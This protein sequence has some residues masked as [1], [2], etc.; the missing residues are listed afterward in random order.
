M[1]VMTVEALMIMG[2]DELR[3]DHMA[4]TNYDAYDDVPNDPLTTSMVRKARLEE[5]EYF[6][7]MKVYEYVPLSGCVDRHEQK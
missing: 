4:D 5:L 2:H 6:K 1:E 3:E 7:S